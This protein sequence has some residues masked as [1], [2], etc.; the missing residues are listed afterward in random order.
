[1]NMR[2][3]VVRVAAVLALSFAAGPIQ[4]AA[5]AVFPSGPSR[6]DPYKTF[7]FRLK[8]DGRVVAGMNSVDMPDVITHRAGGDQSTAHKSPGRSKY[9]A[10]TMERGLTQDSNFAAWAASGPSDHGR[11]LRDL[12]IVSVDQAGKP[13]RTWHVHRA[14]VSEYERKGTAKDD[15]SGNAVAIE[16]LK[17]E[18]E[19]WEQ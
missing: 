15:A 18:N 19:G 12:D 9:E 10:I 2:P 6:L 13:L 3:V 16:H 14:W 11:S 5:G 17:L 4:N 1:M 7:K 8:W